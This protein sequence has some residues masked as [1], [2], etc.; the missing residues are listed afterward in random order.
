MADEHAMSQWPV[1][2]GEILRG[3][4]RLPYQT[5]A[6]NLAAAQTPE[7]A[8]A[9]A[10]D[11]GFAAGAAAERARLMTAIRQCPGWLEPGALA[12]AIERG[13][14]GGVSADGV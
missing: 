13:D 1:E 7:I 14:M 11:S 10:Y 12:D 3:A 9:M 2:G 5:A 8:V 4:P 6:Q